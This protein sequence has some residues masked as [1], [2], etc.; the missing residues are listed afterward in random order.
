MTFREYEYKG[1]KLELA[2]SFDPIP[3]DGIV[4]ELHADYNIIDKIDHQEGDVIIDI[5]A[6]CGV[7]TCFFAKL[8]PNVKIYS[9]EPFPR[10][11]DA[12]IKNIEKNNINNVVTSNLAIAGEVRDNNQMIQHDGN[13]GG[14]TFCISDPSIEGTF[15]EEGLPGHIGAT[16][17]S[18]TLDNV[19]EYNNI[20]QCKM[21]KID[22][23]GAEH[24]IFEAFSF[25]Y[26]I[27]HLIGEFH[28][29]DYLVSKGYTFHKL[30]KALADHG[31][32]PI[33]RGYNWPICV[34]FANY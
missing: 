17:K 24:E 23:E 3:L 7:I 18:V 12:L 25:N 21:L 10:N 15:Y 31:I 6:H 30:K 11:Y 9:Y 5:G 2:N 26:P 16:V 20:K 13:T 33:K 27:E 8:L 34:P 19:F 29:N 22:C 14:S 28:L 1:I 32:D 4:A